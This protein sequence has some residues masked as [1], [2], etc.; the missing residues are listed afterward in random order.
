MRL[1]HL[2]IAAAILTGFFPG[3]AAAS[4]NPAKSLQALLSDSDCEE[5]PELVGVWTSEGEKFSIQKLEGHRYREVGQE[6]DSDTG[7]KLAFDICVAHVAGYRFFD[8]TFQVLTP[9]D[10]PT[11]PPEFPVGN[12]FAFNVLEGYWRPMHIFGRLEIEN[13][14]LRFGA[15]DG[16]WLQAALKSGRVSAASSR[17]EDGEYVLT[18]RSKELKAFVSRFAT[19]AKAFSVLEKL[20]RAPAGNASGTQ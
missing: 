16:D 4:G 1:C 9:G 13:N 3:R 6:A 20:T 5:V 11:L 18:G 19:D 14:T 7:N 10:K 12:A 15:L 2:M 17:N 8:C